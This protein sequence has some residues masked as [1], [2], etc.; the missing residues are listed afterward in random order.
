M[1]LEAKDLNGEQ[2]RPARRRPVAARISGIEN[3][4]Y[5]TLSLHA[6]RMYR[7]AL[8]MAGVYAA[9]GTG[10]L[11]F[12]SPNHAEAFGLIS[13]AAW[14]CLAFW[15]SQ[16]RRGLPAFPLMASQL[17]FL[18]SIP[19]LT[20]ANTLDNLT[21]STIQASALTV[22]LFLAVLAGSWWLGSRAMQGRASVWNIAV[23][24]NPMAGK[25]GLNAALPLLLLGLAFHLGNASGVTYKLLPGQAM[26]FLPVLT[27]FA[28]AASSLGA[29]LGGMAVAKNPF[30]F[31]ALVF[32][33]V[34][35][36]TFFLSISGILLSAASGLVFA[37]AI[38]LGFGLRRIPWGFLVTAILLVGFLNEG[39]FVMRGRYWDA[40]S[41]M[42]NVGLSQLPEFYGE[43]ADASLAI[44]QNDFLGS[45]AVMDANANS[46]ESIFARLDNFQNLTYIVNLFEHN[47]AKPLYGKTYSVIPS[48]LVPRFLWPDKPR[49]HEGQI[50]LNL[51]FNR[52][53]NLDAT[54]TTYVAWGLLPEAV[55]NFGCVAG[56]C[57]LGLLAGLGCGL[58]EAWSARKRLLSVE[59]LIAAAL[60]VQLAVSYEMVA[61]VLVT[62][63]FQL[64]VAVTTF[65][66]VLRSWF[67]NTPAPRRRRRAGQPEI[68]LKTE[69]A[70]AEGGNEDA[71]GTIPKPAV[72]S[73]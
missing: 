46:G 6:G 28:G 69:N 73:P 48:L 41:G 62:S 63:T 7:A 31:G 66:L 16:G 17:A 2:T 9:G 1:V 19:L 55:G 8:W 61:S 44:F 39:K 29:F 11:L 59:G 25:F 33:A 13:F 27:A 47:E 42:S 23:G 10:Y 51:N 35:S 12:T 37:C 20:G 52:Q 68:P 54:Y 71:E 14:A 50:M 56:A 18:N 21:A 65:G 15:R 5:Q 24:G 45:H 70:K 4:D 72:S 26:T 67:L 22:I 30:R 58:L 49:T 60:L 38:G 53:P 36:A 32:W 57:F 3:W 40:D 64:L 43:W 34:F